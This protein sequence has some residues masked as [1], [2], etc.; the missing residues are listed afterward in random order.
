MLKVYETL[1]KKYTEC[2]KKD[3]ELYGRIVAIGGS[4]ITDKRSKSKEEEIAY[5]DYFYNVGMLSA[6]TE[7]LKEM[8]WFD[9][10]IKELKGKG[11]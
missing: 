2:Q 11:L 6:V 1:L 10:A 7:T 9:R 3:R 5:R 4:F 8:G